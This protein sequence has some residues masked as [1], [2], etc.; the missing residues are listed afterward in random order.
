MKASVSDYFRTGKAP[1]IICLGALFQ[2]ASPLTGM[3]MSDLASDP[4]ML[5][6]ALIDMHRLLRADSV[7]VRFDGAIRM[8]A[9][10]EAWPSAEMSVLDL[11]SFA[12]GLPETTAVAA[13]LFDT[14]A[15]LAADLKRATPVLAYLPAPPVSGANVD[16]DAAAQWSVLLRGLTETAC[17]AGAGLVMLRAQPS[18]DREL[19][20]RHMKAI[21]NV[22]RY[23]GKP[24]VLADAVAPKTLADAVLLPD[25]ADAS[26]LSG[27]RLGRRLSRGNLKSLESRQA[28]NDGGFT[29]FDD[30]FFYGESSDGILNRFSSIN[31]FLDQQ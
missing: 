25:D 19:L 7:A 4:S 16:E 27:P 2:T 11:P 24:L 26:L 21:S 30:D 14:I 3:A 5:T 1:R 20:A 9:G 22:T 18:A 31:E 6:R 15:R 10:E 13:T 29:C 17:K 28:T 23:Y 12:P 8:A